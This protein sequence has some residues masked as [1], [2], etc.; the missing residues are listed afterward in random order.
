MITEEIL[1]G[2][3]IDYA[4]KGRPVS[5]VWDDDAKTY[6]WTIGKPDGGIFQFQSAFF[7]DAIEQLKFMDGRLRSR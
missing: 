2:K 7:E 4:N 5:F 6:I 3:L 1:F